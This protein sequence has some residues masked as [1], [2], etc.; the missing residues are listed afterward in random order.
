MNPT[1]IQLSPASE[2][3]LL[4]EHAIAAGTQPLTIREFARR[5]EGSETN[6][7]LQK[8]RDRI[9]AGLIPAIS[10]GHSYVIHWPTWVASGKGVK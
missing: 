6:H 2:A 10:T 7:A 9:D 8:V 3:A 1:P 5:V 4:K